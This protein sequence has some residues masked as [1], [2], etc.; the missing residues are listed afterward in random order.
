MKRI[1]STGVLSLLVLV[2]FAG[3]FSFEAAQAAGKGPNHG[4]IVVANRGSGDISII[5]AHKG[6]I[7]IKSLP[8]KGT[9]IIIR[10]PLFQ[11]EEK[12]KRRRLF[13]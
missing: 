12:Q 3:F 1:F 11:E 13:S 5:D 9:I 4:K 10:L 2:L 7:E 6:E 8:G